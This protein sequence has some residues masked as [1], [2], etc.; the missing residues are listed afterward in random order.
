VRA[1]ALT[2]A[3]WTVALAIALW[4]DPHAAN[5]CALLLAKAALAD[6]NVYV[7][8]LFLQ[9]WADAAPGLAA[10]ILVWAAL[11]GAL[12]LWIRSAAAGRAGGSAPRTLAGL[13]AL[14]LAC[15]LVLE[16]WP[17]S[18]G[19]PHWP[20]AVELKPGVVAF[21][22]SQSGG[23]RVLV[24]SREPMADVIAVA[25]GEGVVRVPGRPPV[26]VGP[27]GARVSV[28]LRELRRLM[29]RRGVSETLY[30]QEVSTQ[31]GVRL[32]LDSETDASSRSP[33]R[34]DSRPPRRSEKPAE[35]RIVNKAR[36]P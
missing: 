20:D 25:S 31:G 33:A 14:A 16:R 12:A 15:A 21:L 9:S 27:A 2:L 32:A 34:R 11:L 6:G 26:P 24:R 29:G 1:L 5:D 8:N 22:D 10:R 28:P 23:Y 17:L 35:R 7:P 13:A 19:A 18:G 4:R 3:A 30:L 36:T